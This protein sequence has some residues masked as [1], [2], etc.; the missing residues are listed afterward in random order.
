MPG[1]F[2]ADSDTSIGV[3][4]YTH[5]MCVPSTTNTLSLKPKKKG[6]HIFNKKVTIYLLQV[7]MHE[8]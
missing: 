1:S 4:N 2:Y 3:P 5:P 8:D 6:K 7:Y